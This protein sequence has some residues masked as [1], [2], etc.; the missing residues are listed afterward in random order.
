MNAISSIGGCLTPP[1]NKKEKEKKQDAQNAQ[2]KSLEANHEERKAKVDLMIN[3]L[4]LALAESKNAV[5]QA[6]KDNKDLYSITTKIKEDVKVIQVSYDEGK[7]ERKEVQSQLI[8]LEYRLGQLENSA[9][10]NE[11]KTELSFEEHKKRIKNQG[12]LIRK[13]DVAIERLEQDKLHTQ[14]CLDEFER[15]LACLLYTSPSPRD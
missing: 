7:E 15:K 3:K 14:A 9:K 12:M 13:Q 11:E 10:E 4:Q 8:Q 6:Q 1:R 5:D 2:I